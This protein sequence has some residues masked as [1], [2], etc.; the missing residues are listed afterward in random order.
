MF[1]S[2]DG[3]GDLIFI[4]WA[5]EINREPLDRIIEEGYRQLAD[6]LQSKQASLL[7][8][9][10]YGDVEAAQAAAKARKAAFERAGIQ[11]DIPPTCVQGTPFAGKGAAGLHAV[12]IR[13]RRPESN[14]FIKWNGDPCGR[15][16]QGEDAHYLTLSDVGRLT[17][18]VG[19]ESPGEEAS[20]AFETV[21]TL[22]GQANWSFHDV[23][24]TW[25]YLH[26]ILDWY[27]DFNKVRNA[28][29]KRMGMFNGNPLGAI[30][31]STGIQGRNADGGWCT[32]DLLAMRARDGHTFETKRLVNPKQNEAPQYG[33]AFARALSVKTD[34]CC[35][36]F[37]SGTA[38]IDERG[39]SVHEGDFERQ[40]I[41]TLENVD[42]LLSTAGAS[43]SDICQATS[44][45]KRAEDV[46]AYYAV[47]EKMGLA[48]VPT[49]CT[50]AD[51]C[52]KELLYEL[53][54][55]A[56]LPLSQ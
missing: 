11:S 30:P 50:L 54:A 3:P 46:E 47:A 29:F 28:A 24:R 13:Q 15:M 23:R 42:A 18:R 34:R 52:R 36:I 45:V 5:P 9:R 17:R 33:S 25:F 20:R 16:I 27:D 7:H 40:T 55:A 32:L 44:F 1:F 37:V 10:I 8:E 19:Q 41:R 43:L 48:K 12:A 51:V 14:S 53:D 39:V 56:V 31:A 4:T 35:Y 38:S 21:E 22:L 6:C 49:V 26:N 2:T